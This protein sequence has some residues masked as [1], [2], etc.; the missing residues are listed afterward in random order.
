MRT[1]PSAV[2]VALRTQKNCSETACK[3]LW[4]IAVEC[5]RSSAMGEPV[6]SISISLVSS[7]TWRGAEFSSPLFFFLAFFQGLTKRSTASYVQC[8]MHC[9]T[10]EN[11]AHLQYRPRTW[12][13]KWFSFFIPS[14]YAV[15]LTTSPHTS[16]GALHCQLSRNAGLPCPA[17]A[18]AVGQIDP[19]QHDLHSPFF[20]THLA[21]NMAI[22]R[23]LFPAAA[24]GRRREFGGL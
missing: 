1:A 4:H 6:I 16:P 24:A 12:R 3:P 8:S 21:S 14:N 22:W 11:H 23:A 18:W 13:A 2:G 10:Y 7:R 17:V 15:P 20:H 9:S 19:G 5:T